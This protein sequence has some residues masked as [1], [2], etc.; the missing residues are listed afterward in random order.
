MNLSHEEE[1]RSLYLAKCDSLLKTNKE[2][3]YDSE[4]FS[5]IIIT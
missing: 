3:V 5:E 2:F 1:D 4:E